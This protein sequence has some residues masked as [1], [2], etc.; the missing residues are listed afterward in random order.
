MIRNIIF[1]MTLVLTS[2]V[3]LAQSK[4]SYTSEA[5]TLVTVR[6]ISILPVFDNLQGIYSQ[7]IERALVDSLNKSHRWEFSEANTTGAI[8]TPD[9]L[10]SDPDAVKNLAAHLNSEAFVSAGIIKGPGGI[11]IKM[12]LFL[13]SD[14]KLLAQETLTG[15]K[16]FDVATVK[17]KSEE[18]MERLLNKL[19]YS[20]MVLSRQG[21]R[22]TVNLGR[23][24]D[25]A[26]GKVLSVIQIIKL[27][28]HPKFNFLISADK[29]VIGKIKLLK[30]DDTLSF[31]RIVTE[32]EPNAIQVNSKL[33]GLQDVV[34]TNTDTLTDNGSSSEGLAER[35]DGKISFGANPAAWLPKKKPTFGM[36]GARIGIGQ[37][38]E[39]VQGTSSS[40]HSDAPAY[41]S[42][43]IDSEL[44][45]TPA[46][47]M[48]A[49]I[50]QGIVNS[51]SLSNYEF[52]MGYN[53]RLGASIDSP[54][55]EG[56]FGYSTYHLQIDE[57]ASSLLTTKTY[58]GFKLGIAGAYPLPGSSPYS[59]G[60][61]LMFMFQPKLTESPVSSG[62]SKDTVNTFGIFGEKEISINLRARAGLDFE[63]YTSD[64]KSGAVSSASQK[65]TTA[66]FG[67]NYLF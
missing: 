66:S 29:E 17:K 26:E 64:F 54:K 56:L 36:V 33:S 55:V 48:H 61:N 25:I 35:P 63:L 40:E 44:W 49:N 22:V 24:D 23:K 58:S 43:S 11:T 60:A 30:V 39:N 47:S 31:G 62:N 38:A 3:T 50:R 13:K 65:H 59:L 8:L 7:P 51:F 10:E 21:T 34:Y 53:M 6:T 20:G 19:P 4:S 15:F 52:L 46:W 32:V 12:N 57:V 1:C 18:M 45:L 41:P 9:E 16:T 42:V 28:R 14:Q 5:D 37:F 2:Q 67:F 27:N